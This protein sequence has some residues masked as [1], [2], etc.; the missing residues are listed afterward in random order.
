M[1]LKLPGSS[2]ELMESFK[3]KL[4]SQIKKPMKEGL[5]VRSGGKELVE[6]FYKVFLV[7]MRDLG[8]PVHSK[9]LILSV[10]DEFENRARIFLVYKGKEPVASSLVIG[11]GKTL[12]NPWASSLKE[13]S[14]LSPNMLLYW[15]MLEYA[16][17]NGFEVFEFGRSTPGEGTYRFKE[18]WGATPAALHWHTISLKGPQHTEVQTEKDRFAGAVRYWQKLP[19]PVTRLIGPYIRKYIGL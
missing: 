4:R 12:N 2:R 3:S 8:S 19:V 15:G 18:Q 6:D 5:D 9:K 14:R 10:L 1:P 7:N 11:F 13:Y 17:D 16:C